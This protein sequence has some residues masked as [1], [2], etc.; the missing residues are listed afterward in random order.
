MGTRFGNDFVTFLR[1]R[2][3]GQLGTIED[4][5]HNWCRFDV[6]GGWGKWAHE[7]STDG[8]KNELHV[9]NNFLAQQVP[10]A[11]VKAHRRFAP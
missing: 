1:T 5:I 11:Q 7:P 3:A 9:L 10:G 6:S 2:L 8:G 4:V